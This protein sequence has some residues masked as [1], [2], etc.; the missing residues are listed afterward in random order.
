[1]VPPACLRHATPTP[2]P[3]HTCITRIY[4]LCIIRRSLGQS[5]IW[6]LSGY[7]LAGLHASTLAPLAACMNGRAKLWSPHGRIRPDYN[8]VVR[9]SQRWQQTA[10]VRLSG[11]CRL[12]R[13]VRLLRWWF[14]ESSGVGGESR[15]GK[16]FYVPNL[17]N[18][19]AEDT[20][21][22]LQVAGAA[23]RVNNDHCCRL[24]FCMVMFFCDIY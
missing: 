15:F 1:M 13:R 2:G 24:S 14:E 22:F 17:F 16:Y 5:R 8:R 10:V 18:R 6:L 19:W 21:F 23:R 11:E 3:T 20:S 9:R 12:S 4:T 7:I